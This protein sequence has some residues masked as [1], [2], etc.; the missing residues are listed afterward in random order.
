MVDPGRQ[1]YRLAIVDDDWLVV[2]PSIEFLRDEGFVVHEARDAPEALKVLENYP[3]IDVLVVDIGL[4]KISGNELIRAARERVPALKVLVVTGYDQS[5][6]NVPEDSITRYLAKPY[7][8]AD[9]HAK[10]V[11]LLG[12]SS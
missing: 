11:E 4:P 5:T 3:D 12:I 10:V 6:I 9:L 2:A 1:G 8:P 7:M